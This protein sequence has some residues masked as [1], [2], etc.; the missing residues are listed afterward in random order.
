M[1]VYDLRDEH[2]RVFAFE[3]PNFLLRRRGLARIVNSIPGV[4]LL[5]VPAPFSWFG[6]E[7]FCEWEL[8][9]VKFVAWEP[10]GDNSRY[11]VGPADSPAWH[12]QI[13]TVRRAFAEAS[14]FPTSLIRRWASSA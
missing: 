4:R 10:F 3:V 11:W 6:E 1:K 8:D 14:V 7:E 13:E 5:R 12:P 2:G 9:G